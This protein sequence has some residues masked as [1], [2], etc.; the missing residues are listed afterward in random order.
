[1][2]AQKLHEPDP[3]TTDPPPNDAPST[4]THPAYKLQPPRKVPLASERL[5]LL[6][7]MPL[8]P[9]CHLWC[10]SFFDPITIDAVPLLSLGCSAAGPLDRQGLRLRLRL[11]LLVTLLVGLVSTRRPLRHLWCAVSD[12]SGAF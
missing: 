2:A 12:P 6:P 9:I 1:M 4:T 11:V 8:P 10:A 5:T 3:T 7:Q